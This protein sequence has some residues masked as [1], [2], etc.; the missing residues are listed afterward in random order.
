MPDPTMLQ[1]ALSSVTLLFMVLICA[2]EE[3]AHA[4]R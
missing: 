3:P 4:S 2:R 1:A